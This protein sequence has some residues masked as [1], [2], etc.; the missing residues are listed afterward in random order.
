MYIRAAA[1]F[2]RLACIGQREHA[3]CRRGR[4]GNNFEPGDVTALAEAL[5]VNKA[6]M[7]LSLGGARGFACV[8]AP[9]WQ[10]SAGKSS[11]LPS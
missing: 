3:E 1:G 5:K 2:V 7:T 8:C 10:I 6:L 11:L 9:P 4:T